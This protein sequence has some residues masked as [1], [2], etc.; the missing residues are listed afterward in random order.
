MTQPNLLAET[1]EQALK[2]VNDALTGN[3][4]DGRQFY[5][6]KDFALKV[7]QVLRT[8]NLENKT[9]Q[10]P[11]ELEAFGLE[12][13]LYVYTKNGEKPDVHIPTFLETFALPNT[14]HFQKLAAAAL[15]KLGYFK[16]TTRVEGTKRKVWRIARDQQ[17]LPD[18]FQS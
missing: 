16:T 15:Q 17:E 13:A 12:Q 14:I 3:L 11:Q 6:D 1:R 9:G 5:I 4:K 7:L 2:I 18:L 8:E 10:S